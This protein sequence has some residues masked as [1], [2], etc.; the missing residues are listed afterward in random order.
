MDAVKA[1]ELEAALKGKKVGPWEVVELIDNGKS[2][3]VFKATDGKDLVALKVFD[4]ELI[5][6]YG[7]KTQLARIERELKLVGHNHPNM[8]T[9]LDGGV[10]TIT[11]NHYIVMEYLPGKNLKKCLNEIPVENIPAL[12]SQLASCGKFLEDL[13]LVHR[14]IKPENIV[15]LDNFTRL[16]LLDFGVL[17]PIGQPGLTDGEGIQWF[18]GTLQ[19]SSPEFLLRQEEDTVLGWRALTLYQ[20]GGVLHDLIMRKALFEEQS[21]PFARLVNAVQLD[22]PQV[23]NSAVPSY[24]ID[25]TRIALAKDP[26]L[27]TKLADW[28]SFDPPV[29]DDG[30]AQQAK[31]RVTNRSAITQAQPARPSPDAAANVD[32]VNSIVNA[33]KVQVRT[34]RD[35]NS[36]SL[37]AVNVSRR[38][39]VVSLRFNSSAAHGLATAVIIQI[40]IGVIDLSINAVQIS[41]SAFA[42]EVVHTSSN[43]ACLMRGVYNTDALTSALENCIYIS[44]DQAQAFGPNDAAVELSLEAVDIGE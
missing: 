10:D 30:A 16:V 33:L 7:D 40:E 24:L 44:I 39:S 14:D 1:A 6:K 4:D 26:A 3:A 38:E 12:A 41:A 5:E 27:R 23:H 37:P 2:A 13:G 18:V 34:I 43:G 25:A 36:T 21:Q 32:L 8:V 42:K 11:N 20:I 29:D 22:L 9:I 31:Q 35:A 15:V 28:S 19:Y 17:R